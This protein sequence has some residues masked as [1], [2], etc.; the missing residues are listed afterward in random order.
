MNQPK[1]TTSAEEKAQAF[2]DFI[3]KSGGEEGYFAQFLARQSAP[4]GGTQTLVVIGSH[5]YYNLFSAQLVEALLSQRGEPKAPLT[6]LNPVDRLWNTK[7]PDELQFYGALIKFQSF[8]EKSPL[9]REGFRAL[10]RNP[11]KYPFY[12]HD[13]AVSERPSPRSL[14]PIRVSVPQ[15][16]FKIHVSQR[17]ERYLVEPELAINHAKYPLA[18][19]NLRFD[20]FLELDGHWYF[21]DDLAVLDALGYFKQQEGTLSLAQE[22]FLDFREK[23]LAKLEAHLPVAHTY[24][25]SATVAQLRAA[26]FDQVPQRLLYLT[27]LPNYVAIEPVMKYGDVEVPIRTQ[28]QLYGQDRRGRLFRVKRDGVAEDEFIS[29]LVKEHPD[30]LEQ[31]D[32][33]LPYFYLPKAYFL[34][35][36]W[37]LDAFEAWTHQQITILGFNELEGN[38]LNQHKARVSVQVASGLNWFNALI[39][40]R[41][42]RKKASL[43]QLHKSVRNKSKFVQLDDGTLGVLPDEWLR[44]F[45]AY[46]QT[47]E[48]GDDSLL[49]PKISYSIL[50]EIYDKDMLDAEVKE[51]LRQYQQKL[52]NLEAIEPVQVPSDLHATLRPY[53]LHGLSWLNF[54]DEFNFGGCLADDMGLGKTVQIIAFILTLRQKARQ[55]P[56][57]LVVPTSLI[58]NWKAEVERFAPSLKLHILHGASRAK[59]TQAFDDFDIILTTYGTLVSDIARLRKYLFGYVF[60]DESQNI[61]NI[62]S[63]RYKAARLLQS[64]NRIVLTGTPLENNTFDLYAQFSFACPGL[65]GTRQYFRNT[66]AIAIDRF[67]QKESALALQRR[68]APFILRRT[69][70]E[71]AQELPEKTEVVLYCDMGEEQRRVYDT[72]EREF[73]DY[74]SGIQEEEIKK[75]TMHVLRGITRLRQIC[76]SPRLLGE[77]R[78]MS[79]A[80]VKIELLMQQLRSIAPDHKVLVFSQFVSM[81]DLIR[82]ELD[83]EGWQHVSLTGSTRNREE[84]V[85]AFQQDDAIRVFLVSLKAGGTGL[86][87]TAADYVFLV[88][89]WWNVAA[90]NQAI[91]R[92]HRIGQSKNVIAV[93][94]IC[95][96][97]VEE[98]IQEMQQNKARLASDL[99]HA[100][101]DF[102]HS[103]TKADWLRLISR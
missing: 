13:S 59:S 91:D 72:Y 51:E 35:E 84:V 63:Q 83:R 47:A 37:F 50:S 81:L 23:V 39:D 2:D 18:R 85:Q 93:R 67:K 3:R 64:R 12:Y 42:G 26:G 77:D 46:F 7:Q 76:N 38:Q 21:C 75:N 29:A 4:G 49:I 6:V 95:P 10:V 16:D 78:L 89:P 32:N 102:F 74:L 80:S 100:G 70:K 5:R 28:R 79:E 56:H 30:F 43:K 40:V 86:N 45:E 58:H 1:L 96:D 15:V 25:R 33:P 62:S 69:K 92:V 8:Y 88:D 41:F 99:I 60:L 19:V 66:F 27:D 20:Y 36:N 87:L 94:L 22:A 48:V 54:L 57:L 97:T 98:K 101:D 61:K 9:D 68:I 90:E 14:T 52:S 103:L 31:L 53:Q 34:D 82:P 24:L 44:R 17:E 73:R 11:L 55:R 65:L 71:V